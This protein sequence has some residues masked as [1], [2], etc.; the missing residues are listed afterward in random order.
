MS[1]RPRGP[2]FLPLMMLE[3]SLASWET[4]ARRS[5]MMA[6]GTCSAAE[7]GRMVREKMAAASHSAALISR[8]GK[9]PS[10]SALLSPWHAKARANA[11][12][13]RRK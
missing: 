6:R 3:L 10:V 4:I 5:A 2:R 9:A 1:R 7:Y 8:P 11:K 13:L 12:R